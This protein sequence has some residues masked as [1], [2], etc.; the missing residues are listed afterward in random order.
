MLEKHG[1]V[2]GG[3]QLTKVRFVGASNLRRMSPTAA[4]RFDHLQPIVCELWHLKQDLLD[5]CTVHIK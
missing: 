3:D 2:V 1:V 5:V 4:G